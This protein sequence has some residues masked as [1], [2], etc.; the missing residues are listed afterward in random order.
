MCTILSIDKVRN[1]INTANTLI[2]Y[3]TDYTVVDIETTGFSRQLDEIIEISALKVRNDKIVG[4]FSTLI[5]PSCRVS[6]FITDLTGINNSMLLYAPKIYQVLPK[7]KRFVGDDILLGHN[8]KFDIGFISANYYKYFGKYLFNEYF[9]TCKMARRFCSTP[10]HKLS[11]LANYYGINT[12]GHH[13]A[14]KDCKITFELYNLI[15]KEF[16]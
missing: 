5:K 1:M 9:D 12:E 13:R 16:I 2:E 6:R 11:T 10:N 15:K 14:L 4:K 8:I 7:F 3:P